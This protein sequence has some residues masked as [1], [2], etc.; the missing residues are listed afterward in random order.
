MASPKDSFAA[1]KNIIATIIKEYFSGNDSLEDYFEDKNLFWSADYEI[2]LMMIL[3]T[4]KTFEPDSSEYQ[5]LPGLF[6]PE[7]D[8]AK[9]D[10][11]FLTN[12]YRK[13]IQH[14]E[15]YELLI[16]STLNNWELERI[17]LMDNLLIRMAIC[18]LQEFPSIPVKVTMNE[19]IEIA[20]FFSTPRSSVFINGI[21]DRL[22]EHLKQEEKINK[23]G[24]GLME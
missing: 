6:D 16:S 21:L 24:R 9:E 10:S 19:Y 1:D 13:T 2:A 23:R 17:A 15:E 22:V 8:Q 11:L 20:K 12:L 3:K 14:E 4:I 5:K 18:E 7:E